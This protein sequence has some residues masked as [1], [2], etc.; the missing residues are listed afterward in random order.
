MKFKAIG[1]GIQL[2]KSISTILWMLVLTLAIVVELDTLHLLPLA[3]MRG[4]DQKRSLPDRLSMQ[5][6]QIGMDL[7]MPMTLDSCFANAMLVCYIAFRN[8]V[9]LLWLNGALV[10]LCTTAK[11]K[12]QSVRICGY[13]QQA[14]RDTV[15]I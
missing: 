4:M 9:H 12:L 2:R 1:G 3:S 14:V 15:V 5:W 8:S 6:T 11:R 10:S 13:G 7:F